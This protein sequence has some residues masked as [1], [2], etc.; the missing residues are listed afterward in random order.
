MTLSFLSSAFS[1]T[2][3]VAYFLPGRHGEQGK[4]AHYIPNTSSSQWKALHSV[5][6]FCFLFPPGNTH[7]VPSV[8]Q[9]HQVRP[10]KNTLIHSV[11]CFCGSG[12]HFTLSITSAFCFL[13]GNTHGVPLVIQVHQVRPLK[14]TLIHSVTCFCGSAHWKYN[15]MHT[16]KTAVPA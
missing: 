11:T 7:G 16:A 9:V 2:T 13:L 4:K 6:D 14:N 10:L 15:L 12:K 8:I 5:N 3:G 1:N